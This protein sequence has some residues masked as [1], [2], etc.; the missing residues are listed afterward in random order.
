MS[1]I[2]DATMPDAIP[3]PKVEDEQ[4]SATNGVDDTAPT[5]V[6]PLNPE[7]A[8]LAAETLEKW[9]VPGIAVAVVHGPETFAEV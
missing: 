3:V 5:I 9:H 6:S 7:F 8:K 2:G 4:D 1:P